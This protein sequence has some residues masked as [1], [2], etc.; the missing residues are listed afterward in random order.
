MNGLSISDGL[1]Y[2]HI[3]HY[4]SDLLYDEIFIQ[5]SYFSHVDVNHDSYIIDVGSNI[6]LFTLYCCMTFDRAEIISIEPIPPI[7]E[8]LKRNTMSY[9]D[10]VVLFNVGIG[11]AHCNGQ[12]SDFSY[13]EHQPGESTRWPIERHSQRQILY[14]ERAN[15][16]KLLSDAEVVPYAGDLP[17]ET[18]EEKLDSADNDFDCVEQED[19]TSTQT[20]SCPM[21]S[22][23]RVIL[24][25]GWAVVD[26]LK[27]DVEGDELAA[28]RSLGKCLNR[29]RQIVV[30]VHDQDS[31][32]LEI[33]NLLAENGFRTMVRLQGP[34]I[35]DDKSFVQ[36]VPESLKLYLVHAIRQK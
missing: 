12:V 2:E 7:F 6:G 10:R 16:L 15:Y 5:R 13:Y 23:E 27:I 17:A 9:K 28:L 20:F 31:R 34:K 3:N 29:V 35:S 26:L 18:A 14:G 4:E 21:M 22:L 33:L 24:E 25:A 19:D 30:E 8:V 1:I 11:N 32:L 36:F